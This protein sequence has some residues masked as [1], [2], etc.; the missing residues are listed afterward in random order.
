[1]DAVSRLP[2]ELNL[3]VIPPFVSFLT[4]FGLAGLAL[5]KGKGLKV[6][7]LFAGICFLGGLLSLDKAFA[8]VAIDPGL[9]LRVSRIDH[10]FVVFFIPVYLHFIHTFLHIA[11]RKWLIGLAYCFSVCLSLFSQGDH[12]LTGVKQYFFGYYATGGPLMYVFGAASTI[13]VV[14]CLYLL[15]HSLGQE[16]D[17]DRKNK[18]KYIILGLG[19]AALLAQFD[20]LPL[21]G[22]GSYP[23]GN[24]VFIPILV[25]GF[26]I[27]KHDL[28]DIGF[29][30][31]KGLLYSLLTGL[32][33]GSYAVM[34][35]LFNQLFKGIGRTGSI[36]FSVFFFL[37]IVFVFD[38]LK[39]RVQLVIDHILF[40]GKYDYQKTLMALSHTMAS[41]LNLDE[42]MEKILR[43]LTEVMYLDSGYLMIV[44]EKSNDFKVHSQMGTGSKA[45][46]LLINRSSPLIKEMG[47]RRREVTKYNFEEWACTR[48]DPSILKEDFTGLGGA[49]II[50]MIFKGE[51]NGLLVLGNKRSGDLFTPEDLELLRTLADQCAISI[52]N[53]KAYQLIEDLNVNLEK[54]VEERTQELQRALDEKEKAQDLLIRSESLA[55]VGAL[56]A[57]VA[58][59]LNNPIASAFS[60][61]QS[62]VE[63]MEEMPRNE[64]VKS[65]RGAEDKDEM[66]D[67]LK[68]GLKEL[69]RAKDI[70]ASLLGVSRQTEEYSEPVNMNDVCKDALK[71]LS[72]QYKGTGI[73][74]VE[75]YE[76]SLPQTKGNFANLGQV[77]LNIINNAIQVVDSRAGK[78]VIKTRY[79]EHR[80]IVVFECE[81]DGPGISEEVMKDMFKP[82]FTT[83]EVGKGT[84]LGLYISHEIVRRHNGN[85]FVQNNPKGGATFRVEL[86]V[87]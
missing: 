32:L 55:S 3:W 29:M 86:P 56:A 80:S 19:V 46:S 40:K 7:L 13:N 41:M 5:V 24:L 77:C 47:R 1:M 43:A 38:H 30:I 20:L 82:F 85:I 62:A 10:L 49:V 31:Q 33:T 53:A 23:L 39:K 51:I 36:Y 2:I 76:E 4:M 54:M 81:D 28:L 83:K 44:D 72:N 63:T 15:F 21:A 25:L 59:E 12:Y 67:D 6:N 64:L 75:A 37:V 22:I 74:I 78:I 11:R 60:L 9:V 8:S 70:V 26:A 61:V 45:S 50:P 27:L 17:P 71:V 42:I 48:D 65:D 16:R 35:I 69:N 73:E 66:I 18:T 87:T 14:Y 34:I 57:G 68:F 79:D 84:G 58:H 52:E